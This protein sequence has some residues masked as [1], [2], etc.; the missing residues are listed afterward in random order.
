MPREIG[1]LAES[2]ETLV[3]YYEVAGPDYSYWSR[4]MHMHFGVWRKGLS[5]FKREQMLEQTVREVFERCGWTGDA[6]GRVLDAGCGVGASIKYALPRYPRVS[7]D[8]L[9][10]VPWQI[11]QARAPEAESPRHCFVLGDFE[12]TSYPDETFDLCYSIEAAVHGDGLD[13]RK[14]LEE[15]FR[16]LKP[17]GQLVVVDCFLLRPPSKMNFLTRAVYDAACRGWAVKEMAML[18]KLNDAAIAVGFTKPDFTDLS[19]RVAPSVMHVPFVSLRYFFQSIF[20]GRSIAIESFR[21]VI[22]CLAACFLGIQL[23]TFRYGIVCL[24]KGSG[25]SVS[26]AIIGGNR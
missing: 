8:G 2:R 15:M 19:W 26:D 24:R 23:N 1:N 22:S 21:H 11:D 5:F 14:Y 17:G 3:R 20:R 12:K 6:A 16:I 18:S 10:I 13:K 25:R 7:F 9:T 4:N